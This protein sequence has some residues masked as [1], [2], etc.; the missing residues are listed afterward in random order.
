MA[1]AKGLMESRLAEAGFTRVAGADE[2]GRGALAGP[3]YAA[4][5]VL[6]ADTELEG[7]RDSKACTKLQRQRLAEQIKEVA[8]SYCVV[9]VRHSTIDERGLNPANLHA[10]RRAIKGLEV[11]PDY[12]L[13]DCFRLRRM[14]CPSL[15]VKK[16]DAVS[17]AVA[18]ASI[19]AKVERDAAMRRYH[20]RFPDYGF[21]TNVGYGT[22]HHWNAL[23]RVGPSPIHRL[24]FFGVVGFPDQDGVIRPHA[25]RDLE[26][27]A[28]HE[29]DELDPD[30][31]GAAP[32]TGSD[33][34][35]A[36]IRLEEEKR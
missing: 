17:K 36:A 27:P 1:D 29:L 32:G 30:D 5:V 10:L 14:P 6:P 11:A 16:G 2:V 28:D 23:Q 33:P 25:A 20:A 13:I 12:A 3:L 18:A 22:R 19:L 15:G 34:A 7:L 26:E 8:V 35:P 9:K 24:S 31:A 4:A 21:A